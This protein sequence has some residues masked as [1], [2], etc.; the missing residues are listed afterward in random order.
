MKFIFLCIFAIL[1]HSISAQNYPSE[2]SLGTKT[3]TSLKSTSAETDVLPSPLKFYDYDGDGKLDI[4]IEDSNGAKILS[5]IDGSLIQTIGISGSITSFLNLNNDDIPDAYFGNDVYLSENGSYLHKTLEAKI[6]DQNIDGR[7]DLALS[8]TDSGDKGWYLYTQTSKNQY[9]S[10]EAKVT[11]YD[12]F[13]SSPD[14]SAWT[15]D[16][17][18]S[19]GFT[20]TGLPSM[21]DHMIVSPPN[22]NDVYYSPSF[23]EVDLN[24]DLIPDLLNGSQVLY[25]NGDGTYIGSEF[26]GSVVGSK[27]FNGDG[28]ID[29]ITYDSDT[30]AIKLLLYTEGQGFGGNNAYAKPGFG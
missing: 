26:S 19:G 13:I 2:D 18:Y 10:K 11:P 8:K 29:F 15:D 23:D 16:G 9:A 24:G 21:S 22:T 17:K 20:V 28:I 7:P 30:K 4:V 25:N 27:D 14:Y 12:E 6:W 1:T 5:P 3:S